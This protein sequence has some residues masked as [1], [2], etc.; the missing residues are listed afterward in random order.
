MNAVQCHHDPSDR[1][2]HA[3][4]MICVAVDRIATVWNDQYCGRD[5]F[6]WF[7][8]N[9]S[10]VMLGKLDETRGESNASPT[11]VNPFDWVVSSSV[12]NGRGLIVVET[13]MVTSSWLVRSR[14]VIPFGPLRSKCPN[15]IYALQVVS[16]EQ[17]GPRW[18]L[19]YSE[20]LSIVLVSGFDSKQTYH[21]YRWYWIDSKSVSL[22]CSMVEGE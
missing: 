7:S 19:K 12:R 6:V 10:I 11:D 21:S 22:N 9:E 14:E 17:D 13:A 8:M 5:L 4:S 16:R 2:H 15:W 18:Y 3:C 1:H 20:T